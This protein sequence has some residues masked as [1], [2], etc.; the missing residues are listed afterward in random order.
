M[1]KVIVIGGGAS[2]MLAAISAAMENHE[3]LLLEKNEKLGKKI[4]ITGKGRCNFTN[5][6]DMETIMKNVVS[7]PR[8]LYSAFNA[9]TNQDIIDL[10]ESE[11]CKTKVE[12]GNRV[13]PVSDHA[14]DVT[15]ALENKCRKLN[16]EIRFN[17]EVKEIIAKENKVKGVKLKNNQVLEADSVI[18]ATGG[19]S[20]PS[21]GSTGDGYKFAKNFNIDVTECSPA[22]VAI[23]A[24]E[25]WIQELGW[26]DLKNIAIKIG[27]DKKVLYSDFGEMGFAKNAVTGPVIISASSLIGRKLPLQMF[28]DL[29]PALDN[30]T[31]DKRILRDFSE[32]KNKHIE[33]V[34]GQLVPI[35]LGLVLLKLS[36]INPEKMCHDITKEERLR[37]LNNIKN[38]EVNL[39]KTKS[40]N[41]AIVTQGG[42]STKEISP[43][44]MESKKIENLYF[45]GEVLDVDGLT[46]GYNLQIAFS[47]GYLA[48]KS[49]R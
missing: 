31:L 35:K 46:G 2:G 18:V 7:N 10:I 9:F 6:S 32:G 40:F 14:S 16:V 1:S 33:N 34:I 19:L 21:T 26:L 30:E 49:I 43:S 39:I 47:T 44:T 37:L 20:Y 3:V 27:N 45:V 8:F 4:Y 12:R 38:L 23:E 5:A 11:G 17:T 22:L 42:V 15:K 25:K 13:F 29:K 48:G 24:K 41:E 36:E 28:I